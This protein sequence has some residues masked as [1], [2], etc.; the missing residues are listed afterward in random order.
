MM[1]TEELIQKNSELQKQLNLAN[2][3]YYGDLVI[4]LRAKGTFKNE[5]VIEEKAFEIL[6]D[7]LESQA[8]GIDAED[9][10]WKQPKEIA[11]ELIQA[12]PNSIK[13]FL[14]LILFALGAYTVFSLFPALV[15]PDKAFDIGAF[16]IVAVYSIAIALLIFWLVGTNVYQKKKKLFNILNVILLGILLAGGVML[17]TMVKTP[18]QFRITGIW[19]IL[20]ILILLVVTAVLFFRQTRENRKIWAV[21]I[22]AITSCAIIGIF[23]RITM[24]SHFFETKTGRYT[25]AAVLILSIIIQYLLIYLYT[26]KPKKIA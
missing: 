17:L 13:D 12:V 19:G 14:K 3:S 26:R 8:A 21:F 24:F 2:Q 11:D 20:I 5:L 15:L 16:G 22:P 4:Y 9:Y 25:I 1:N 7:I 18:Y 23:S 10:F 6:Q